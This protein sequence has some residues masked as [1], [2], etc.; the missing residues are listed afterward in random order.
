MVGS[1]SDVDVLWVFVV[2]YQEDTRMGRIVDVQE[3]APGRSGSPSHN[4][5]ASAE[6]GGVECPA[7]F[8][9][10]VRAGQVELLVRAPQVR[11]FSGDETEAV[12]AVVRLAQSD[13]GDRGEC[14]GLIGRFKGTRENGL[15][16][17]RLRLPGRVDARTARILQRGR[18]E[19]VHRVHDRRGDHHVAVDE[20]CWFCEAGEHAAHRSCHEKHKTQPVR[21][22]GVGHGCPIP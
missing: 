18:A 14:V 12:L 19:Q 15:F 1:G 8:R 20:L 5:V 7:Q 2:L 4:L 3:L 17:E 9:K 10:H 13:A 6:P 21:P 11:R 16:P 22:K